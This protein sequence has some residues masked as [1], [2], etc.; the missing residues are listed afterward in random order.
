[1]SNQM[2]R[3]LANDLVLSWSKNFYDGCLL[4]PTKVYSRWLVQI[5]VE[6]VIN[7]NL[8]HR[9]DFYDSTDMEHFVLNVLANCIQ[10]SGE[11]LKGQFQV[12]RVFNS[13]AH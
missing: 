11:D 13:Y 10:L 7:F 9:F 4:L 5:R 1:M 6:N 2:L 3:R 12:P 8:F